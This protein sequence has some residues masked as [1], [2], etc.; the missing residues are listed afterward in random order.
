MNAEANGLG[1]VASSQGGLGLLYLVFGGYRLAGGLDWTSAGVLGLIGLMLAIGAFGVARRK[2]AYIVLSVCVFV[3]VLIRYSPDVA[4]QLMT[5]WEGDPAFSDTPSLILVT[6]IEA[7]LTVV[8]ATVLL[9]CY[10]TYA[11]RLRK[12][13][14]AN[15]SAGMTSG[16]S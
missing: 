1:G 8:P 2:P 14:R 16:T 13:P 6:A 12:P 7:L 15:S 10:L 9:I 5:Y 11:F 4:S 3:I